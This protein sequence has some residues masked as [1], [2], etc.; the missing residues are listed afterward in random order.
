MAL[1]AMSRRQGYPV[2]LMQRQ[3]RLVQA[4]ARL[5]PSA[6]ELL[7]RLEGEPATCTRRGAAA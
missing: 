5:A 2:R 1:L 4:P 7:R 6:V 3:P